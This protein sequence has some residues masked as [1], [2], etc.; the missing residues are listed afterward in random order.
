VSFAIGCSSFGRRVFELN[1]GDD[2]TTLRVDRG[3]RAD[4]AAVIRQNDLVIRLIVHDAVETG[5]D[6]NLFDH[7]Q[8]IQIEHRDS[9]VAAICRETVPGLGGDASAMH[10]RRVRN[11]PEYFAGSAF[12]YHH[13]T[14]SRNKH[15]PR[16]GFD[17]DIVGASIALDIKLFNLEGLR[18][19]RCW[20]RQGCLSREPQV[21]SLSVWSY[22]TPFRLRRHV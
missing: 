7:C 10:P 5:A 3:E 19:A 4:R 14:G 15:A 11:V 2:V 12:D 1:G 17:S 6:L 9:L 18:R 8:R 13:V 16:G 22:G 20:V 21:R